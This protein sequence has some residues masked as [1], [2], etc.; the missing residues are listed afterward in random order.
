MRKTETI[1]TPSSW[2][3]RPI[4]S[5]RNWQPLN[6]VLKSLQKPQNA[7]TRL[8]GEIVS[9]SNPPMRTWPNVAGRSLHFFRCHN[10]NFP[11]LRILQSFHLTQ[12]KGMC[13]HSILRHFEMVHLLHLHLWRRQS[14]HNGASVLTHDFCVTLM[15]RQLCARMYCLNASRT[16]RGYTQASPRCQFFVFYFEMSA[17]N[18][19]REKVMKCSMH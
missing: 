12:T 8:C 13:G 19:L 7:I 4:L 18:R 16:L 15:V 5:S 11:T 10:H 6:S 3:A 9:V 2:N 14:T 17:L 1:S